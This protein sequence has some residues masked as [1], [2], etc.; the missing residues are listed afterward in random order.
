MK[1]Y[2]IWES[3]CP[4][5]RFSDAMQREQIIV[6]ASHVDDAIKIMEWNNMAPSD[7]YQITDD[8]T[9]MRV[10]GKIIPTHLF[11]GTKPITDDQINYADFADYESGLPKHPQSRSHLLA[12]TILHGPYNENIVIRRVLNC[13]AVPA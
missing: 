8:G 1:E 9:G 4:N 6:A 13:P 11:A 3:N 10:T 12:E 2:Y 5:N 7:T